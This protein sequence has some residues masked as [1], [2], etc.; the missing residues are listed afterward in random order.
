MKYMDQIP[1]L[2]MDE[3]HFM[4]E[5]D[6]PQPRT[7]TMAKVK[8]ELDGLDP[9]GLTGKG[10]AVKAAMTGNAN[11]PNAGPLLT[12]LG[13]DLAA[14]KA[15]I[16][17]QKNAAKAATDATIDR[18]N[19]LAV[20]RLDLVNI[21]SHVQEVSSGSAVIIETAGL[22]VKAKGAPIGQLA[23]VS[24]LSLTAGDNPGEVD[25]HWNP[26]YGRM[27]YDLARCTGDPAVEANWQNLGSIS[28]SKKTFKNQTS[29]TRVWFRV[30]AKAP[31]E[32]FDGA[33]SQPATIIVP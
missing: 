1:V 23:Q 26:V 31:K 3:G 17:T 16:I 4:D 19:A 7:N 28:G 8:L 6:G 5:P 2:R 21:G 10:D 27:S 22:G 18:D 30:R 13:T 29:G 15:K 9:D 33:W 11:F 12:K 32:E 24:G 20:V 14:A 25:S